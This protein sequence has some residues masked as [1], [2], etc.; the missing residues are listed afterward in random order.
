MKSVWSG[1]ISFGLVSIPINLYSA[2]QEHVLG[3]KVLCEKC[4]NPVSYKRWCAHCKKEI[5]WDHVVKG[6]EVE[7][8]KYV[9]LTN[10]TIKN[11]KPEKTST[12]DIVEFVNVVDIG[13][14]YY[15]HHYY[16]TPGQQAQKAYTLLY[17]ALKVMGKAAIGTFVM[18]DKQYVC[19][20]QGYDMGILISTLHY[21]YEI[22]AIDKVIKSTSKQPKIGAAELKLAKQL[23]SS[24]QKNKFDISQFKDTFAQE[25]KRF[26]KQNAQGKVVKFAKKKVQ[27]EKTDKS[28]M[29]QLKESLAEAAHA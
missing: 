16:A 8:G 11:L 20:L 2:I 14:I 29:K 13:P 22:R 3:F 24:L 28:L 15:Q 7:K 1:S 25:L 4:N 23:I 6:L 17:Q 9:V 27:L 18:R 26:L 12:I 21:D 10:E 5:T 19:A